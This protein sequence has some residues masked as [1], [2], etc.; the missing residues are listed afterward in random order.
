MYTIWMSLK[1]TVLHE[2]NYMKAENS[3]IK[4]W[5]KKSEMTAS[6]AEEAG[7]TWEGHENTF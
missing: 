1:H 3:H 5:W 4:L 6:K 7:N 2:S